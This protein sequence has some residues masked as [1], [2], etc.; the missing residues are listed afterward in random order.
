MKIKAAVLR[1]VNKPLALEELELA[2][3]KEH[4]VLVRNV[5]TG[6]CHSDLHYVVGDI[7]IDLPMVLGHETA[8]VIE[9]VGP[10]VTKHKVGDHVVGTWM[11]PCGH[12]PQCMR[13]M[14]NICGGAF[15]HF[16]GGKL[17][18]GTS[19][20]SDKKGNMVR[21]G[22]FVSGFATYSVMPE[23]GAI[24]LPKKMPLDQAAFLGC[25]LP[26]G[27]GAVVNKANL[28]AGDSVVVYGMG[29]VGLN[30]VRAA[31]LRHGNPVIAVDIEGHNEAI[32]KEFGAT[33]FIDS[34]KED[35]VPK[36]QGLTGGGADFV[37]E[38]IGD[39]GAIVQAYWSLGMNGKLIIPGVMRFDQTANLPLMLLPLHEKS[40]L[41]T[42]Y[43]AISTH[44][45]IPRLTDLAMKGTFKL[46]K[47]ITKRIKLEQVNDACD[48]MLKRQTQGRWVIMFE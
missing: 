19:R 41:G 15:P 3:P 20:I 36:I 18:D 26:T 6:F 38:A 22:F 45:D 23:D 28:K 31:S 33:H 11:V 27:W 47:L 17:L 32:A 24:P 25:C 44:I 10:G 7:P 9:K 37:F 34:S 4:E 12:C 43:G 29:G 5:A 42:L 2:D 14:G 8:G 35:P 30:I 16:V 13:G 1:E 46:D 40:I 39:G 48:S 21:H